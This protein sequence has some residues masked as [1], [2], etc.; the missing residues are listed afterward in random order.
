[1]TRGRLSSRVAGLVI[2]LGAGAAAPVRA[3]SFTEG[4]NDVTMLTGAGW[5]LQNASTPGGSSG[6]FQGVP[7]PD[8]FDA[9][10]SPVSSYIAANFHNAGNPNASAD[11]ISN[12]LM[13]PVRTFQSGDMISFW[14]RTESGTVTFPDRLQL[15]LSLNG[16]ST[17]TGGSPTTKGDFSVL[18]EVNPSYLT[19]GPNSYPTNWQQYMVILGGIV[20]PTQ[21]RFALRYFVENGGP[22]G[23]R[24][25]YIGIDSL[26]YTAIPEPAALL[27]LAAPAILIRKR[28][29]ISKP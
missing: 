14:T 24:S 29:P 12:W 23:T 6:W 9:Q 8:E 1:V 4:F 17:N 18:L 15:L 28:R 13:S 27:L 10:A 21:G 19:S 25:N 2:L 22:G 26:T 20:S 3:Q 16:A 7:L 5:V 11:T